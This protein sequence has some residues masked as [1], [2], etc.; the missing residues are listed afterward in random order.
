[1]YEYVWSVHCMIL[2]AFLYQFSVRYY[3]C[4]LKHCFFKIKTAINVF[5]SKHA[6]LSA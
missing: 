3:G 4:K 6:D 5:L 2:E 1:M